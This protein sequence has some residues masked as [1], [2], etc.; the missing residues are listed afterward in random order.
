MD[1]QGMMAWVIPFLTVANI[2]ITWINSKSK[3]DIASA[4]EMTGLKSEVNELRNELKNK[5]DAIRFTEV[6]GKIDALTDMVKDLMGKMHSV[7][8]DSN[9]NSIQIEVSQTKIVA[10]EARLKKH[11]EKLE[12]IIEKLNN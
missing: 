9:T 10:I 5:V 7:L 8:N 12:A 4:T 11:D 2:I 6:V 1:L 3:K